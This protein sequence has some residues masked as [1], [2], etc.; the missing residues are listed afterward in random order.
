MMT[1]FL[2]GCQVVTTILVQPATIV[3]ACNNLVL[4]FLYAC[5]C[6]Y[7]PLSQQTWKVGW[8]KNL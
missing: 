2:L 7:L 4:F 6:T 8:R 3:Q 1:I 5:A